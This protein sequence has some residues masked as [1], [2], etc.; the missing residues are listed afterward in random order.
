MILLVENNFPTIEQSGTLAG[1]LLSW[2]EAYGKHPNIAQFYK[3]ENGAC[4]VLVD[5]Q[6]VLVCDTDDSR[7]EFA[8]FFS[9]RQDIKSIYTDMAT[10]NFFNLPFSCMEVMRCEQP[11]LSQPLTPSSPQEIYTVLSAVF[12]G[13]PAFEP[14][15]LDV[16]Y[17]MRHHLCHQ[18]SVR[19]DDTLVSTAMT[20]AEWKS[21]AL[22]GCVATL[23]EHRRFGYAARCVLALTAFCQQAGKTAYISPKNKEAKRLYNT[24]GFKDFETIALVERK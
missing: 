2:W 4:A 24:L 3:D 14:W 5:G 15:Y 23:P 6:A 10:A 13:F 21:G 20:V 17:R 8:S 18:T 9:L 11:I 7:K 16:S 1:R 22:L 19:K 12:E